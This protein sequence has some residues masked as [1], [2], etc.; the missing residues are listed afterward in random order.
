MNHHDLPL[1]ELTPEQQ[2][3]MIRF[4]EQD[5]ANTQFTTNMLTTIQGISTQA[6]K[7]SEAFIGCGKLNSA[8]RTTLSLLHGRVLRLF[9]RV[10]QRT[11]INTYT[12]FEVLQSLK[13]L[14]T[15]ISQTLAV[16]AI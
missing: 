11:D 9:M 4:L 1:R 14:Q 12:Q 6:Q 2:H 5:V 13:T 16:S 10:R 15:R 8:Q 7:I 3:D